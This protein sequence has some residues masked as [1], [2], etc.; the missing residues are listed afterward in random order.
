VKAA[1]A[2][3]LLDARVRDTL[4][5]L[6]S[7]TGPAVDNP[8]ATLAQL[9][10]QVLGFKDAIGELVNELREIRFTDA[11]GSEQLRSEVALYER[12]LDRSIQVLAAMARLRIDERLAAISELQAE[13]LFRAVNAGFA[14]AGVNEPEILAAARRVVARELRVIAREQW[15]ITDDP[16]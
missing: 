5:R 12:A 10:G 11:K 9:A 1:A 2:E 8:L 7:P 6:G 13:T 3:R 16:A 14:A 4:A 15:E